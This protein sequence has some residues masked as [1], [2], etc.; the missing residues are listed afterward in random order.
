M[1]EGNGRLP[2]RNQP[3]ALFVLD[4]GGFEGWNLG[5]RSL[6]SLALGR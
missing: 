5:V 2:I 4:L 3:F 6:I 1:R